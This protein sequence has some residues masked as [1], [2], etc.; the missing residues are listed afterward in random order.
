MKNLGVV[1]ISLLL[2]IIL[3][4]ASMFTVD[5]REYALVKRLGEVVAI[6]KTPGL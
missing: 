3:I 5:Q 2:A 4:S 6:E 1:L